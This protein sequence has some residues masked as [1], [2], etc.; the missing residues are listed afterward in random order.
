M[1]SQVEATGPESE[2]QRGWALRLSG[3]GGPLDAISVPPVVHW[4][5]EVQTQ[6]L[7]SRLGQLTKWRAA[8]EN[9]LPTPRGPGQVQDL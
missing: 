8:W 9:E 4:S 6:P 1:G 3:C 2:P 5:T 7:Q